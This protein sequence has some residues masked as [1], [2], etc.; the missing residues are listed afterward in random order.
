MPNK[1]NPSKKV[2]KLEELILGS[3]TFRQFENL[4]AQFCPFEA[5]GM[6]RQEIKHSHFLSYILDANRPHEFGNKFLKEFLY[7]IAD[8]DN[9]TAS[10]RKLDFHFMDLSNTK[11][12]RE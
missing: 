2:L 8:S 3:Q 12:Q 6:I 5:T 4:T 10:Y 11:V 7:L 9:E 1:L